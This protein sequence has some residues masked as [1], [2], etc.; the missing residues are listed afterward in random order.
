MRKAILV[1]ERIKRESNF[2]FYPCANVGEFRR[3]I[4]LEGRYTEVDCPCIGCEINNLRAYALI[5]LP[6][7][8]HGRCGL[9]SCAQ[10]AI[11]FKRTSDLVTDAKVAIV[12]VLNDPTVNADFHFIYF[13]C[14]H[15]LGFVAYVLDDRLWP[16]AE[17]LLACPPRPFVSNIIV[18]CSTLL[19]SP[20]AFWPIR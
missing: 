1:H 13:T 3:S 17:V 18:L 9:C 12:P 6:K 8:R 16:I 19:L 7:M 14:I 20:P 4:F 2:A 15:R 10:V 11:E 5:V